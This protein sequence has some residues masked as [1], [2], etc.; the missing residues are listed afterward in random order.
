MAQKS[1]RLS[2]IM[3]RML[4]VAVCVLA[5]A[6][7]GW[8]ADKAAPDFTLKDVLTGQGILP[9]PVQGQGGRDQLFH[10]LLRS[11]PG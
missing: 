5:L 9:Q 3:A 10:L 2:W 11:V 8:G 7:P 4:L 6:S 1:F